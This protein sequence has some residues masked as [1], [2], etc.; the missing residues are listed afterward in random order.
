M[1]PAPK[2][3]T[4]TPAAAE[5]KKAEKAAR[6][7][8]KPAEEAAATTKPAAKKAASE[9]KEPAK[10]A[11]A[12]PKKKAAAEAAPAAVVVAGGDAAAAAT[13]KPS[14]TSK[15]VDSMDNLATALAEQ[16]DLI[17]SLL[18]KSRAVKELRKSIGRHSI[19]AKKAEGVRVAKVLKRKALPHKGLN[20][21]TLASDTMNAFLGN[22]PGSKVPRHVAYAAVR[23]YIA[24]N[25]LKEGAPS[26]FSKVDA[27]L[28]KLFPGMTEFK[29]FSIQSH[30][31]D[32]FARKDEAAPL[33]K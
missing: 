15:L 2:T 13:V 20:D 1:A 12:E 18:E 24:A 14:A 31:K 11:A 16:D 26:G 27:K 28:S 25:K 8:A 22:A 6:A 10:K 17:K 29:V 9:P 19:N 4:P 7:A 32:H 21:P 5:P 23:A 3:N 30:L 33:A